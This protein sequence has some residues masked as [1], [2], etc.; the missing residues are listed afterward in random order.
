M[1]ENEN[2]NV[3]ENKEEPF[4]CTACGFDW[5]TQHTVGGN[6]IHPPLVHYWSA[7]K[8]DWVLQT[9]RR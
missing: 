5:A 4:V 8:Q 3:L 1:S 7:E 9:E 2:K 6:C